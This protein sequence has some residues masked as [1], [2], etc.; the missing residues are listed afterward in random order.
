[1]FI[2]SV[3]FLLISRFVFDKKIQFLIRKIIFRVIVET[4]YFRKHSL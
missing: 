1:M 4:A 3:T 2:Y